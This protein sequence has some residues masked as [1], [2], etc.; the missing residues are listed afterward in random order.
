MAELKL[1]YSIKEIFDQKEFLSQK[2]IEYFNIPHYQRGYKWETSNVEKLLNDIYASRLKDDLF[3]CIQN[4]T[5]TKKDTIYNVIDGQ[6]RLTTLTIILSYLGEKELVYNKVRFPENSIRKFTNKTLNEWVTNQNFDFYSEFPTWSDVVVKYPEYDL[7]DIYHIV[8]VALA[9]KK[10]FE[11]LKEKEGES[12]VESFKTKF[13]HNVKLI[14]NEVEGSQ[15]EEK[16]FGN[17][18]SKRIPLDGSDLIRA[19]L[20]TRV[21]K[22][23]AKD[24]GDLKNIIFVNERRIKLGWELDQINAWWSKDEVKT[25]FKRFVNIKSENIGKNKLFNEDF[26]PINNLYLLF[27]ESKK[28]NILS[29]ELIE[30]S[31]EAISLYKDITQ[32]HHTLYDWFHDREIYHLLG[33]LFA[34][35][36]ITRKSFDFHKVWKLWKKSSTRQ[37]FIKK[38]IDQIKTFFTEENEI[39]DFT[40]L[41]VNWYDDKS[42]LLIKTLLLMDIIECLK[43]NKAFLPPIY[44]KKNL[45]DIEHIF[46][47]NPKDKSN[48][49]IVK[50]VRLLIKMGEIEEKDINLS[51]LET[52]LDDDNYKE[53]FLESLVDKTSEI[54]EN[55]IGN[56]VLLHRSLNR[57][58]GNKVYEQK[59]SKIIS[60]HNEGN[61]IQPHTFK[62][63]VRDFLNEA[64]K[65]SYTDNVFW[66]QN[67]IVNN[68]NYIN[69]QIKHFFTYQS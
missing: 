24:E 18:N 2:G 26:Y 61:F 12:Y 8:Q 52:K 37:V 11:K 23:E 5:I 67:D 14:V 31:I 22:E 66:L 21:A 60:F 35:Q 54:K 19:I 9:V 44:F 56:L 39:V 1:L 50:Y 30:N 13:L 4:I 3:Y 57:G 46:P 49:E 6:Q 65:D 40:N 47:R 62:V 38:L 45:E 69:Q 34:N 42:D 63:F 10:W 28:Q 55:S 48:S 53:K 29:L 59:R 27:A 64:H 43:E 25:Y 51:N 58:L 20:I 7:Q 68:A 15:S 16:I 17:L 36:P 32:L 41:Q 33:Y